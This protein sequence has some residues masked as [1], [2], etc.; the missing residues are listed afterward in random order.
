MGLFSQGAQARRFRSK[1]V[2]KKHWKNILKSIDILLSP[3]YH[4][5]NT[6]TVE[7]EEYPSYRYSTG[8]CEQWNRSV[9]P[10][11]EWTSEG[12]GERLIQ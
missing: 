2:Q 9:Y 4:T 1:P 5:P 8:S 12:G 6:Q 11:G 3:S 7:E 10:D